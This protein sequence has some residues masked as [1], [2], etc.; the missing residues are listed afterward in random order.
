MKY[1]MKRIY[2]DKIVFIER[3]EN[4]IEGLCR[5]FQDDVLGILYAIYTR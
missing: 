1:S 5:G 4:I 2:V 3:G